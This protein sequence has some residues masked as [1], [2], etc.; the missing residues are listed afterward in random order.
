MIMIYMQQPIPYCSLLNMKKP[1][2][3]TLHT[4]IHH[5]VNW[6]FLVVTFLSEH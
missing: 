6:L 2:I 1:D 4:I 3:P 5:M